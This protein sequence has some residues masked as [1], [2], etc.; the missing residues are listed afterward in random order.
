MMARLVFDRNELGDMLGVLN[1]L[2]FVVAACVVPRN[3]SLTTAIF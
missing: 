1:L 3:R 2:A